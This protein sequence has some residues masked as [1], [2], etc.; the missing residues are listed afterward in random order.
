MTILTRYDNAAKEP[1]FQ[2]LCFMSYHY[3]P[4]R[5]HNDKERERCLSCKAD[6]SYISI[7]AYVF[8]LT[9]LHG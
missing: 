7:Y 1:V 3:E 4:A 9:Y 6:F 5:S 8:L 2:G